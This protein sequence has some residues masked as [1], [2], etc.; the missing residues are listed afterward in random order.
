MTVIQLGK[1]AHPE[2]HCSVD[3]ARGMSNE[4]DAVI[5]QG[6]RPVTSDDPR[7]LP[8]TQ[9]TDQLEDE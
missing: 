6:G 5:F 3:E 7:L 9:S 8:S 4:A 1:H 2:E